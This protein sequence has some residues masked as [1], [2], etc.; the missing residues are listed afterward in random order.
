MLGEN[1][2]VI[3]NFPVS[4]IAFLFNFL[5]LISLRD[6]IVSTRK[7]KY[8]LL[9]QYFLLK[10]VHSATLFVSSIIFEWDQA[11]DYSLLKCTLEYGV[12]G[13]CESCSNFVLFFMWLYLMWE[14]KFIGSK[15]DTQPVQNLNTTSN[16]FQHFRQNK[17]HMLMIV[18]YSINLFLT[19][20]FYGSKIFTSSYSYY[21]PRH[22]AIIHKLLSLHAIPIAFLTFIFAT[23]FW[24]LFGGSQ[25]PILTTAITAEH[26]EEKRFVKYIKFVTLID[27]FEMV[28]SIL[29]ILILGPYRMR[30]SG[31]LFGTFIRLIE[32]SCSLI[33]A[34]LFFYFENKLN[35]E[36]LKALARQTTRP[37][38]DNEQQNDNT[39]ILVQNEII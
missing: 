21:C 17:R 6:K 15:A 5:C 8:Q 34:I 39:V 3:T 11:G 7:E 36:S 32:A 37:A 19:I 35:M 23:F 20:L 29:S 10:M 26:T 14:R 24:R 1:L 30:T 4:L 33:T 2:I 13:F 38:D 18:Y 31:D 9:L 28:L 27:A 22:D 25:D 16:V 12:V